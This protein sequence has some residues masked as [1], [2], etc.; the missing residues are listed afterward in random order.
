MAKTRYH[1][2]NIDELPSVKITRI[3]VYYI[4]DFDRLIYPGTQ[5]GVS[6]KVSLNGYFDFAFYVDAADGNDDIIIQKQ[7]VPTDDGFKT[8]YRSY[9]NKVFGSWVEQNA[10]S[11]G[12]GATDAVMM[13]MLKDSL[14]M[15]FIFVDNKILPQEVDKNIVYDNNLKKIIAVGGIIQHMCLG[16]NSLKNSHKATEYKFWNVPSFASVTLSDLK[17]YYLYI[18]AEKESETASYFI[19]E[20]YFSFEEVDGYYMMIVGILPRIVG[21]QREFKKLYGFEPI[22]AGRVLTEYISDK[23]EIVVLSLKD[24]IFKL[25]NKFLFQNDVLSALDLKPFDKYGNQGYMLIDRRVYESDKPYAVGNFFGV[26]GTKYLCINDAP[27]G[28]DYR[29]TNYFEIFGSANVVSETKDIEYIFKLAKVETSQGTPSTEEDDKS[30]NS[31]ALNYQQ[32]KWFPIGWTAVQSGVS[33][34]DRFEHASKRIKVQGVW[35][36]F[37]PSFLLSKYAIDGKDGKDIEFIFKL[38]NDINSSNP[39]SSEIDKNPL[40]PAQSFQ[41]YDWYPIGW[42]DNELSVGPGDKYCHVAI[43]R[44]NESGVWQPFGGAT[45][46]SVYAADGVDGIDS[47]SIEFSFKLSRTFSAPTPLPDNLDKDWDSFTEIEKRTWVDD[48]LPVDEIF[49]FLYYV[50]RK[51][52]P[53]EPWQDWQSP[54]LFTRWVFNGGQDGQSVKTITVFKRTNSDISGIRP[55]GGT[56]DSPLPVEA[57]YSLSIPSGDAVLWSSTRIFT[58][59]GLAPQQEEWSLNVR[60]TSTANLEIK[61]SSYLEPGNPTDTPDWWHNDGAEDD[62]WMATRV[63]RNGEYS[64]WS[65]VKI[66][67]T[68]GAD[69]INGDNGLDGNGIEIIFIKSKRLYDDE[70]SP[71]L[72]YLTPSVDEQDKSPYSPAEDY[73]D[74][75]WFPVENREAFVNDC[76]GWTD[77]QQ[78]VDPVYKY[79]YSSRRKKVGGVWSSFGKPALWA[80]YSAD[81][82][83]GIDGTNYEYIYRRV[84]AVGAVTPPASINKPFREYTDI[85]RDRWT[86]NASGVNSDFPFE[87]MSMRV[88]H[89]NNDWSQFSPSSLW[90][91]WAFNG[92][93]DGKNARYISLSSNVSHV[94]FNLPSFAPSVTSFSLTATA[95]NIDPTKILKFKFFVKGVLVDTVYPDN[96][97]AYIYHS[98]AGYTYLDMPINCM[99]EAYECYM[100]DENEIETFVARDTYVIL[101]QKEGSGN[102]QAFIDN[103]S[104]T[105]PSTNVGYVFDD[106][107]ETA[108]AC[109]IQVSESDVFYTHSKSGNKGTFYIASVSTYPE[110]GITV[111]NDDIG[112]NTNKASI[113]DYYGFNV[114]IPLVKVRFTILGKTLTGLSFTREVVQII[115]KSYSGTSGYG[116]NAVYGFMSKANA[117]LQADAN[118]VVSDYSPCN[119]DVKM[120]E[121]DRQLNFSLSGDPQNLVAGEWV[122]AGVI[123]PIPFDYIVSD[124]ENIL[125][126][127]SYD[128]IPNNVNSVSLTLLIE[129]KRYDDSTFTYEL[130]QTITK[131]NSGI[132]GCMVRTTEWL[133]GFYYRNDI[134][135]F[136]KQYRYIDVIVLRVNDTVT[137]YQ[138]TAAHNG[139]MSAPENK[140]GTVGGD[141]YWSLMEEIPPFYTS[142]F[143][144][145]NG[146][147]KFSQSQQLLIEKDAIVKAGLTAF[148]S[149][150]IFSGSND[151]AT[152][153]YRVHED[154]SFYSENGH[155]KGEIEATSG[156]IGNLLIENGNII[157]LDSAGAEVIRF[158]IEELPSEEGLASNWLRLFNDYSMYIGGT[159]TN[160]GNGT[161][162]VDP[163]EDTLS[164]DILIPYATKIVIPLSTPTWNFSNPSAVSSNSC[165]FYLEIYDSNYNLVYSNTYTGQEVAITS[166]GL[167]HMQITYRMEIECWDSQ[168]TSFEFDYYHSGGVLYKESVR[169]T[170][171]GQ[172]GFYSYFSDSEFF[173][174]KAG[175]GLRVKVSGYNKVDIPGVIASGTVSREGYS[176]SLY[177]ARLGNI[178]R[179]ST[180]VYKIEHTIG[181][182]NY[183]VIITP[184]ESGRLAHISTKLDTYVYV[185]LSNTSSTET[186]TAFD[187]AIMGNN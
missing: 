97:D 125:K 129:G 35:G 169:K 78:G 134:N 93:V 8:F 7:V 175:N 63:W 27:S 25:G 143:I 64:P 24:K 60:T 152:A 139:L 114:D 69:G 138:A 2:T 158:A 167:Y 88:K 168:Q 148:G 58:S 57:G 90:S 173:H 23:D 174:F 186:N 85:E 21:T 14:S 37:E 104:V 41:D 156:K 176:S 157:G 177:G 59:N 132:Q 145:E 187:F 165:R 107:L 121:G 95:Y 185:H 119:C 94:S 91:N 36:S 130:T 17:T 83:S 19:S 110:E 141:T 103:P 12:S 1:I 40:S 53:G 15:Q 163:Y 4:S 13:D 109:N 126:I 9:K 161:T 166:A 159:A 100:Y 20:T 120:Y 124:Y 45:L 117:F 55:S 72:G 153:P 71:I 146:V 149:Y 26:N 6:S 10:G 127:R 33:F 162:N 68:D 122:V 147:I 181:H 108:A 52:N 70:S 142:L 179:V 131:I 43:R 28:T 39:S 11:S 135:V 51:R 151:P 113:N 164:H 29:D 136:N 65:I 77:N 106:V 140:P 16:V 76:L 105:V 31:P 61:F 101:G 48:P 44:K 66:K 171:I 74:D 128:D 116:K 183:A 84:K 144:A 112:I 81:G 47:K 182:T 170:V 56:F 118:G 87:Y 67:G 46:W 62:I 98:I 137:V 154:G 54:K 80:K 86:N 111:I 79:E 38:S 5:F 184:N 150:P 172:D 82:Q 30:P 42:S 102:I 133:E 178:S 96:M 123:V 50:F 75:D 22:P 99:V 155:I 180:G 34:D 18:R 160:Y 89:A 115:S 32:D 73:Q 49:Q 3:R 92:G